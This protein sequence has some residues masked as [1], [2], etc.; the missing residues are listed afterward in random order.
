MA[1]LAILQLCFEYMPGKTLEDNMHVS[2]CLTVLTIYCILLCR[3]T[4]VKYF[5]LSHNSFVHQVMSSLQDG[6]CACGFVTCSLVL[7]HL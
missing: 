2:N 3:F 4:V 6:K 1:S 5:I 7:F